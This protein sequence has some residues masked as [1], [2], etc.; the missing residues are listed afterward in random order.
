MALSRNNL[1]SKVL[2]IAAG[3]WAGLPATGLA[4]KEQTPPPQVSDEVSD[5]L[6]T[7]VRPATDAKDWDKVLSIIETGLKK[8]AP[9][10]YDAVLLN[11]V[12]AQ[13]YFQKNSLSEALMALETSLEIDDRKHYLQE[14]PKLESLYLV[15]QL[16]FQEASS[17][18]DLKKQAVFYAKS[19]RALTRWMD[20]VKDYTPE[21]VL[22]IAM[23]YFYRA[24]P[25]EIAGAELK[26]DMAMM[27]KALIWTDKGLRASIR[28]RE[29][30]YQL[31][32]AQLFQLNR[33]DA[34]AE[35]LELL[36]K[37]K[38]DNRNHW[39]QLA[40]SYL[41]LA[42]N[43]TDNK[44]DKAAYRYNLRAILAIERAQ[45]LG[46]MSTP[47]DNYNL[48]GIYFNIGQFEM[49]CDLLD[50]GLK[51]GSIEPTRQNWELLANSYQQ[52]HREL[53]AVDTLKQAAKV[54]PESGQLEYQIAQIYFTIDKPREAFGHIK[55]CIK[56]G[57]T[58]KPHMGWLFYAYLALDL[59]EYDDALKAAAEAA[60]FPEAAKE[61]AKMQEAV[62]ATLQDRENRLQS[63]F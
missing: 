38:P 32:L 37:Q 58:E 52:L 26:T 18:K 2:L 63:S 51:D 60:K 4:Q 61:A 25:P 21:N 39:Q 42:S 9:D 16:N 15:A 33:I 22:F 59:K 3:L 10:S 14:K 34:A 55:L 28:P 1:R 23:L 5:L 40:H 35:L 49:A 27:E 50:K 17:S 6:N 41:Q 44:D 56:K 47:K 31:K 54:F 45:K 8:A 20:G 29:T 30:F 12:K 11:Q 36:V 62:K 46:I 57:G 53:K 48:V 13:T 19:D 43:A 7:G 24:Q